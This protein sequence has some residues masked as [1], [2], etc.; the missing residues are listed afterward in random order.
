[1]KRELNFLG[2]CL[3]LLSCAVFFTITTAS[4]LYANGYDELP[5]LH[6]QE[7]SDWS[8][9][10][11][12]GF[13]V[14]PEFEGSDKYK[15]QAVPLI[16]I[17]YKDRFFLSSLDGAVGVYLF[18]EPLWNMG[19]ALGYNQGRKEKDS[20]L[21]KGMGNVDGAAEV[22]VF[23]EWTPDIPFSA[24]LELAKGTGDINGFTATAT[25]GHNTA[26][27]E[28]LNWGNSISSTYSDSDYNKVFFGITEKQ[29]RG[30]KRRYEQYTPGSGIKDVAYSTSLVYTVSDHWTAM[31]IGQYKRLT[32][33]AADSPLVKAGSKNQA[34]GGLGASYTF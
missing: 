14:A 26:L 9:S 11:G 29:S 3:V 34:A 24:K 1:M 21:L 32:G 2:S 33:P 22:K 16:N 8:V 18:R 13:A 4:L 31:V 10:L 25:L 28:S 12:L 19:L 20:D 23:A 5:P 15:T 17:E 7:D 30:S 27:S 6:D